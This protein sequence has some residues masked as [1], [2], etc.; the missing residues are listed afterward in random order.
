M[1][2]FVVREPRIVRTVKEPQILLVG[3]PTSSWLFTDSHHPEIA[4]VRKLLPVTRILP[5]NVICYVT[6]ALC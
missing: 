1:K 3:N 2:L 4:K 6:G 5:L